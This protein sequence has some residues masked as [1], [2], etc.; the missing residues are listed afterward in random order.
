MK[1]RRISRALRVHVACKASAIVKELIS[2]S[3]LKVNIDMSEEC[4]DTAEAI[5]YN[6]ILYFF[7]YGIDIDAKTARGIIISI[8]ASFLDAAM[9]DRLVIEEAVEEL[10]CFADSI[11]ENSK[12]F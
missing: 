7:R 11:N 8:T 1:T 6:T 12:A 4:K 3:E 2:K 5:L 10:I 9:I